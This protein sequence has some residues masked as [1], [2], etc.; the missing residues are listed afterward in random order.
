[1]CVKTKKCGDVDWI[2]LLQVEC[3]DVGWIILLQVECGDVGWI[4]LL[5]V[6]CGDVGW[7]ILLQDRIHHE[8]L[9]MY[10]T[11]KAGNF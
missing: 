7:I 1:M 2:I 4:I 11:W 6:E 5:Q 10:K 8:I 9:L 3:G